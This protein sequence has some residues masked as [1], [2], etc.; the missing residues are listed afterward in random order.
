MRIASASRIRAFNSTTRGGSDRSSS[1]L[2]GGIPS[3]SKI[4]RVASAGTS[5]WAARKAA[6]LNDAFR[7]LPGIPRIRTIP[8]MPALSSSEIWLE[9]HA[10]LGTGPVQQHPHIGLLKPESVT[11]LLRGAALDIT[12]NQYQPLV[13]G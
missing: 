1:S 9:R 12:Q 4:S 10:N 8:F 11:H 13:L 3:R 7:R 5:C 2:N 6:R